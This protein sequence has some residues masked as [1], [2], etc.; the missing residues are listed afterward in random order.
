MKILVTG[1]T[2][3]LGSSLCPILRKS[4][5]EVIQHSR[6]TATEII[7]DLASYPCV[8][9]AFSELSPQIIVNL[10]GLTNVDQCEIDPQS[11]YLANTHIVENLVHWI[12]F[13][14]PN[15]HLIQISTDHV[16]DGS[17][18]NK[19]DTVCLRNYYAFSKF[20]GE[21][22]ALKVN[23][24]V[25]RTNFFGVSKCPNRIT[26]SD[27][28]VM[29]FRKK[30]S[31]SLFNDV[32]FSPLEINQLSNVIE[33]VVR[34]PISGIFNIGANDGVTKAKFAQMLAQKLGLSTADAKFVSVNSMR[35]KAYRPTDMRLNVS[36]FEKTFGISLPSLS[37]AIEVASLNYLSV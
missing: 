7:C 4:G 25:L 36:K 24:T 9:T 29:S 17:G 37:Q 11:A 6:N 28:L 22:A 18:L 14:S 23:S 12:K 31:I 26:L 32:W 3:L 27:W 34:N 20:A 2:G 15:T 19:E 13:R 35:L 10:A 33:Y 8:E 30:S 16:Y 21:Q 5:H 1:S